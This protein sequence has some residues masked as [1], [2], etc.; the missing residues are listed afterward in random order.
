MTTSVGMLTRVIPAY[1][2]TVTFTW[3]KR[4]F[5]VFGA[6]KVARDGMKLKVI[7]A[8]WWCRKPFESADMMALAGMVSGGN[9]LLCQTCAAELQSIQLAEDKT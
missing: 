8:C 5:M 4:E 9:K 2:R 7:K 3:C 1:R 6:F